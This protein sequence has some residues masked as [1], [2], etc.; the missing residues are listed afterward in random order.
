MDAEVSF[1]RW[2]E[3]RRK[4]LDLTREELAQKVGCSVSA[5]RK[6]ETDARRPSKQLAKL[7][8]SVLVIPAEEYGTFI[9]FAR[10]ELS[11][12]RMKSAPPLPDLNLLQP[13]QTLPN[14]IPIPPTPLIGREREFTALRQ[15]LGDPQCRLI[16]LVGPG[17]IGKTRLAME[18]ACDQYTAYKDG[19]GF[20]SLE[21]LNSASL[22]VPAIGNALGLTIQ[23]GVDPK[24]QLI[25]YLRDKQLL[26]VID[27]A[28]H[29][30]D[31]VDV[32]AEIIESTPHVK[33]LCTS[34]ESLNLRGEWR[35]EVRGLPLP[36]SAVGAEF[37][38]NSA[39]ILFLQR[40]D[41]VKKGKGLKDKDRAAIFHICNMVEGAP[42]AIELSAVWTHTLSY[43]E[44]AVE[45]EKSLDFL[46]TNMRDIPERHRSLRAVF[47][48]SWRVLTGEERDALMR[49]SVFR[50]GFTR[51]LAEQV[52]GANLALLSALVTKSL[53]QQNGEKRYGLHEMVRNYASARLQHAE[54]TGHACAA[55]L[56]AFVRLAE[57]IEP[58]LTR[59]GQSHWLMYMEAEHDNFRTA[60]HWAFESGD[61]E[62][63]LRLTG[64]LWR[65]WYLRSHL[66]EGS[67]WLERALQAAGTHAPGALRVK[68]LNGAGLLAYYQGHFDQAKRWL[69]ECLSLQ[70]SLSE[71]N[72]AYAQ[73][74]L[75]LVIHDQLDFTRASFLYQETLQRFRHLNDAYGIIRTLN[76]QGALAFDMGDLDMADELFSACLAL[77]RKCRDKENV[78]MALTNL[79][80]TAVGRGSVTAI[81]LCQ[82]AITLFYELGNKLGVAFSLEGIAAGF[83][84][85]SQS[86]RAVR[87]FGSANGLRKTIDALPGGTHVRYLETIVQQARNS[88]SDSAFALAWSEGEAMP[89]EQAIAY[90]ID[91]NNMTDD[92]AANAYHEIKT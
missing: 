1:G 23:S 33:I 86:D 75:A 9:R 50:G 13:P 40:V 42:L 83:T 43:R 26:L 89:M 53:V 32:F 21:N 87:L 69:E 80:W 92:H 12:E 78:A 66:V 62:S 51:E 64:A 15:M 56:R 22:I 54:E 77:A 11:M 29:L 28:E 27:N 91:M 84:L 2:L 3:K 55:H 36:Q 35:F 31:G 79:G 68:A 60:L 48:H 38:N 25:A 90:A 30:L 74:T 88:L 16:T 70:T 47:D 17:G 41:Q 37:D 8:A 72:I 67:Q 49:L 46:S 57:A 7:F 4:A 20:V 39:V 58:E 76:S 61:T 45:I 6:I 71:R 24:R 52:A 73:L 5:L 44:I 14:S 65:F 10:G 63:G 34:R 19:A 85:A 82:E 18:I 59:S 81:D